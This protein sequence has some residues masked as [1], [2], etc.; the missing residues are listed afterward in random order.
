VK[1]CFME[2]APQ[3]RYSIFYTAKELMELI[4]GC[5]KVGASPK[6]APQPITGGHTLWIKH[7]RTA[8]VQ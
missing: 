6:A 3:L 8:F 4:G 7:Y 2:S 5:W 1:I